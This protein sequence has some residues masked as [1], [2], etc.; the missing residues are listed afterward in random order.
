MFE[1]RDV[2]FTYGTS[3]VGPVLD[4]VDLAVDH[5]ELVLLAGPTGV[6]K[7]TLL[8]V[9]A[10]LVPAF[11]GGTLTGDLVIDGASVL[12]LPARERAHVVGYVGQNPPAWFVT[13]TVEEELA[14]GMEQLGL[15]APTMRRRVEETLDLLGIADLRHRDLRTLSGG[16][17]QRVAIGSVLSTHP[18]LLVLDEP[19]S[20]LDPTAAEDV[21]ATL[22]RLVH[23][24]GVSVLVAEHRLE[25]VVP[26]ADRLCLLGPGGQ[27]TVGDPAELLIEAP[28]APPIVELGRLAGWSPLPLTV[29]D[30]RRRSGALVSRLAALAPQPAEPVVEVRGALATSLETPVDVR[31]LTVA[32]GSTP[33]LRDVDL[34][35]E[36]GTVTALMGRNGAG[37]S[38]LLWALQGRHAAM[39]GTVRVAGD[40]PHQLK[41]DARRRRTGLVPQSPADLLY[42]ETVAQECSAADVTANAPAGTCK[43]LLERLTPGISDG[44]HPRDL[45]EGQRLALAVAIVLT[46]GP[47]V[48][49]LDEPTR[50]LD[51]PGKHALAEVLRD[52]AA[53]GRAILVATHDVEFVAQVADAIVVLAEGEVVSLGPVREVIAE[54]PAFAPQVTKILGPDWLRVDEVAAALAAAGTA[55]VTP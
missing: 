40:D 39:R 48:L 41:P 47:P 6:G 9:M 26:F 16:Q 29:R 55:E 19:T 8:G 3:R 43:G 27:V 23:D 17:Q 49:L 4:H 45:S 12:E 5:G 42:L 44:G 50:G 24:L 30:A 22:T 11:T 13:D 14:F 53:E 28:I 54:S 32:H 10:G 51:Y 18:R 7:S 1:L 34:T 38:T 37:K 36:R 31:R 2:T 20:A 35:L 33:A 21:L 46:A 25:R 52:L 15:A